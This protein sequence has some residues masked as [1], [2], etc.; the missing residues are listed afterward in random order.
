MLPGVAI[1]SVLTVVETTSPKNVKNQCCSAVN[2]SSLA[3]DIKRILPTATKA[4]NRHKVPRKKKKLQPPGIRIK[5]SK[6]K[7]RARAKTHPSPY[8][9]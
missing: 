5:A 3:E 8:K 4:V 6:R 9:E 1:I 2:A 7:K